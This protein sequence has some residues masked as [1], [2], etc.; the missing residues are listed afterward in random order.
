MSASPPKETTDV[1]EQESPG[2]PDAQ[3]NDPHGSGLAYEFEVKGRMHISIH[4]Q[5]QADLAKNKTGGCR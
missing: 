3:M 2:D 4:V 5:S 1:V